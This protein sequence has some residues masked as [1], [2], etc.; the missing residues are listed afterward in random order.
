MNAKTFLTEIEQKDLEGSIQEA[1]EK[2]S[3]EIRVHMENCCNDPF[4][5]GKEVFTLLRMHETTEKNGVLFYLAVAD[6]K[7]AILGDEGINS[8]V[9][10]DFWDEIK[11]VMVQEFAQGRFF[12][13]LRIG[14][15][16]A[17][18][19]LAAFFPA[20]STDTNELPNTISFGD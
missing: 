18:D 20:K 12:Q 16:M 2:T 1:E 17:G 9:P 14:I 10:A 19:Q 11:T 13:G 3:G 7:F 6:R 5:R 4:E 15:L 8:K